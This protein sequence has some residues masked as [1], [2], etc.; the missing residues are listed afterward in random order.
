MEEK[1][2]GRWDAFVEGVRGLL[3]RKEGT[4]SAGERFEKATRKLCSSE[5]VKDMGHKVAEG[6]RECVNACKR[7][8]GKFLSK[9]RRDKE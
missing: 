6:S 5:K 3:G 9:F 2:E 4:P 1:P 8:S 7:T